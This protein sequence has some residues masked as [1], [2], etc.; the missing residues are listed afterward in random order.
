M[1]PLPYSGEWTE[2][3]PMAE[4]RIAALHL[5]ATW[6]LIMTL[7][8]LVATPRTTIGADVKS[9]HERSSFGVVSMRGTT[10]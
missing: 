4:A 2:E 3:L 8:D 9:L 5:G 7:A 1:R 6:L 10:W